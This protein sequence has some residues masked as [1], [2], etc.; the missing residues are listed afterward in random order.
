MSKVHKNWRERQGHGIL[1]HEA[2]HRGNFSDPLGVSTSGTTKSP[3]VEHLKKNAKDYMHFQ[4]PSVILPPPPSPQPL[5]FMSLSI[6]CISS[7]SRD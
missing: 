5:L 7:K 3:F 6:C 1:Y 2:L 4:F